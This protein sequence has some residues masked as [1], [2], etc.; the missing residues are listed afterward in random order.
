MT[1]LEPALDELRQKFDA[2]R[3]NSVVSMEEY[4]EAKN[5]LERAKIFVDNKKQALEQS[6]TIQKTNENQLRE[7]QDQYD[8]TT[9]KSKAQDA[10][11]VYAFKKHQK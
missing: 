3:L 4:V 8:A 9:Q 6:K 10:A 11:K 1:E 5:Q 7:L 2:I